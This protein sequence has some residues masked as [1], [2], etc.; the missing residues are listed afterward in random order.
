MSEQTSSRLVTFVV[1]LFS[2]GI[3]GISLV[4]MSFPALIITSTYD[5][6]LEI[7]PFESSPWLAP[8][9]ISTIILLGVGFLYLRKK[10]PT[11]IH[12]IIDY[13]LS[14][15]ISKKVAIIIGIIILLSLIHI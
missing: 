14:F 15:E 11:R 8:I 7:D 5:F 13:I 2:L 10:L 6:S 1:F 4:S 9:I 3:I 12:S